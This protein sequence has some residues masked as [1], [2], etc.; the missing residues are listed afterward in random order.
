MPPR[1]HTRHA[2]SAPR[3][4]DLSCSVREL[5]FTLDGLGEVLG[6]L[7]GRLANAGLDVALQAPG[8]WFPSLA[9][10]LSGHFPIQDGRVARCSRAAVEW[11]VLCRCHRDLRGA[12]HRGDCAH[13]IDTLTTIGKC[14]SGVDGFRCGPVGTTADANGHRVLFAPETTIDNRLQNLFEVLMVKEAPSSSFN[15]I[16]AAVWLTNCHPFVDGNGRTSRILFN[17][18]IQRDLEIPLFY[19]PIYELA[20]LSRQG[21]IISVRE[22]EVFGR[23]HPLYEFYGNAMM[24]WLHA[25]QNQPQCIQAIGGPDE[26][27]NQ[28]A[29]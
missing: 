9:H 26:Y 6:G 5:L 25:L 7:A 3:W 4:T 29:L 1:V 28:P 20:L 17:M 22:A 8:G 2:F 15:A 16:L 14:V 12:L 18:L 24:I 27:Y 13:F 23:W 11:R 10:D 19:L 21:F